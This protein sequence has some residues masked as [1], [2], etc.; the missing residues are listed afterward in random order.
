MNGHSNHRN[1]N[2]CSKS[3]HVRPW[4]WGILAIGSLYAGLGCSGIFGDSSPRRSFGDEE[5]NTGSGGAGG[6]ATSSSSGG[7]GGD[8]TTSSSSSTTSSSSSSS[9]G[10]SSSGNPQQDG[11]AQ[12]CVDTINMHRASIGLP[13]YQRWTG[14]EACTSDQCKQDSQ[15]GQAHGAFGQCGE[16]AQNECPGWPGPP[17]GMIVDCLQMMWDEGPGQDFNKHGHY[18]N[19]S[20]NNYSKVSCGFY[21]TPNGSWWAIQNF[22]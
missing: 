11:W 19:M 21:Q 3:E 18:I 5:E 6:S 2:E 22:Q 9:G 16:N 17:E 20:S 13:P 15:T 12:L 1:A 14:A 7:Q 4:L 10:S 8:A